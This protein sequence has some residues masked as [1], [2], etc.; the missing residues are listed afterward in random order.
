MSR[1]NFNI[2]KVDVDTIQVD[3]E[4]S[5][6]ISKERY[7]PLGSDFILGTI[8]EGINGSEQE[9]RIGARNYMTPKQIEAEDNSIA[10]AESFDDISAE[11]ILITENFAQER[12]LQ[13][14]AAPYEAFHIKGLGQNFTPIW[15]DNPNLRDYIYLELDLWRTLDIRSASIVCGPVQG[16]N[17]GK[18]PG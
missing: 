15:N 10:Y 18:I 17:A 2:V 13:S 16:S 6:L 1:G 8:G 7:Q 14:R 11:E 9:L 12:N 5:L 3:K 4:S